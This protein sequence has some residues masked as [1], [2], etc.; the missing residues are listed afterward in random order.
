MG[1]VATISS[2]SRPTACKYCRTIGGGTPVLGPPYHCQ[3]GQ[4]ILVWIMSC[5]WCNGSVS[6]LRTLTD[7]QYCCREHRQYAK[8]S[9]LHSEAVQRNDLRRRNRRY[10]VDGGVLQVSWLDVNGCMKLTRSR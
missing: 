5:S 8:M 4:C 2:A 3:D 10:A 6:I 1:S 9:A 7:S